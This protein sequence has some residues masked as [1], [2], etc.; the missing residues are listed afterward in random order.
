[1]QKAVD[2]VNA[3][4]HPTNK[5]AATLCGLA[6]DG[7]PFS[8]SRTNYW[9]PAVLRHFG[10][11]ARIGNS[12][13]TVHAETECIMTAPAPTE[14]GSL[15]ITDPFCPNC[16]KNMAE[17]GLKTIYIDHK[18]FDKDFAA[19]RG[20]HFSALSMQICEKAGISVHE[21]RRKERRTVPILEIPASYVP[22]NENPVR[23]A[24][25]AGPRDAE[26]FAAAARAQAADWFP[27]RRIAAA[28]T[29]DGK[30]DTFLLAACRHPVV[31]YSLQD[32]ALDTDGKYSF[33]LE[34]LNR[35]LMNAARLGLRIMDGFIYVSGVPTAREQVNMIGAGLSALTIGDRG[36]ARDVSAQDALQMLADKRILRVSSLP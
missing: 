28:A 31:G 10:A 26:H 34:P 8:L 3:S 33:F 30:G 24:P 25:L 9:P 16:A 4:P 36:N 17:A 5:I 23:V 35:V 19:R 20:H 14:G 12:S 27:G 1:M 18:G 7:R 13:G 21:I 29:R 6:P 32:D 2:I 15:F 11:D 22:A